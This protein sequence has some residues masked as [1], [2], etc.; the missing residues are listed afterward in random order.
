MEEGVSGMNKKNSFTAQSLH[1]A[2]NLPAGLFVLTELWHVLKLLEIYYLS[3]DIKIINNVGLKLPPQKYHL[4]SVNIK[5][6]LSIFPIKKH[7]VKSSIWKIFE[8]IDLGPV[9]HYFFLF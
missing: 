9:E 8:T 3:Q 2:C 6:Y 4:D 5:I 1:N 7:C